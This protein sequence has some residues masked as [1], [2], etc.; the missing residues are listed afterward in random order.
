MR[1]SQGCTRHWSGRKCHV[2]SCRRS[3]GRSWSLHPLGKYRCLKEMQPPRS[4]LVHSLIKVP[5]HCRVTATLAIFVLSWPLSAGNSAQLVDPLLG[6]RRESRDFRIDRLRG[7]LEYGLLRV[8]QRDQ[9]CTTRFDSCGRSRLGCVLGVPVEH[10][11][12]LSSRV[13]VRLKI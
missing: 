1:Q 5:A 13:Y 9:L 7:L 2:P 10:L 3:N 6:L 8:R 11:C 12:R 4:L